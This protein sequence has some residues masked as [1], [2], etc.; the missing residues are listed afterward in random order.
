MNES[1]RMSME[2]VKIVESSRRE[3]H[4]RAGKKRK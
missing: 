2:I 3:A 1:L 4:A